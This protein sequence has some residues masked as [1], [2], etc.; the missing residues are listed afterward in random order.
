MFAVNKFYIL[1]LCNFYVS[2][3]NYYE[4]TVLL[5]ELKTFS[6]LSV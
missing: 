5:S 2:E 6:N 4:L 1:R 3:K